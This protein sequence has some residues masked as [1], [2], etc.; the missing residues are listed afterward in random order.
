MQP[1]TVKDLPS[2]ELAPGIRLRAVH[3][4]K[5]TV[6]FVELDPGAVLPEHSHPHDQVSY[7]ARGVLRLTVDG[8]SHDVGEGQVLTI[9]G[10]APHS[11]EVIEGPVFAIDSFGPKRDDYV[12]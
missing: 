2:K 9:P 8:K 4:D 5:L 3:L 12:F 11:G 6:T 7:I 1:R 10:G